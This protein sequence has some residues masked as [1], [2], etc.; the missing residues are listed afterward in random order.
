[1]VFQGEEWRELHPHTSI[2]IHFVRGPILPLLPYYC[3]TNMGF[4]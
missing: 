1:M 2:C 4:I 3:T